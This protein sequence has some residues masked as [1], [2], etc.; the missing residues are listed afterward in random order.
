[1]SNNPACQIIR[2]Y[3][4]NNSSFNT[5]HKCIYCMSLAGLSAD[6]PDDCPVQVAMFK[7]LHFCSL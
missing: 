4:L 2:K 5:K 7:L 1:M 3:Q 6:S